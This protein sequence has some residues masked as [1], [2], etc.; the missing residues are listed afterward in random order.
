MTAKFIISAIILTII[1]IIA[2]VT[3][4]FENNR[5]DFGGTDKD[6]IFTVSKDNELVNTAIDDA[7]NSID[8]LITEI[9]KGENNFLPSVKVK[10]TDKGQVEYMWLS[11]LKYENGIFSGK[12]DNDPE[13]VKTV[14]YGDPWQVNKGEICDWIYQKDGKL[15]GNYTYKASLKKFSIEKQRLLLKDYGDTK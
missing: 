15:F 7:R 3:Q 12:I 14:Y 1:V 8:T 13:T 10:I 2:I 11:E 9:K 4:Y 6:P 5:V